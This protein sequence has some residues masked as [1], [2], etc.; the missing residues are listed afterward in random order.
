[1]R[2][3]K[4]FIG[5]SLISVSIMFTLV[6]CELDPWITRGNP[7]D[8]DHVVITKITKYGTQEDGVSPYRSKVGSVIMSHKTHEDIGLACVDC[9]HKENNDERIKTCAKCHYGD[10]GY[11]KLHGKCVDCHIEVRKGPQ[12]CM[13]CH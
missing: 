7:V 5:L 11:E 4:L 6:S 1:V 13:Q 10:D 2:F 12:K 8:T 3:L 9:H